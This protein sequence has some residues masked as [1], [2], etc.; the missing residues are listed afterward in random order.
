MASP[1]GE[2]SRRSA[3]AYVGYLRA[4][5]ELTTEYARGVVGLA[6]ERVATRGMP[7]REHGPELLPPGEDLP[8]LPRASLVLE[9]AAGSAA[10]GAFVVENALDRPVDATVVASAL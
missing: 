8:S 6:R 10:L 9:A 2:L 5:G 3:E 4:V 1:I 7:F